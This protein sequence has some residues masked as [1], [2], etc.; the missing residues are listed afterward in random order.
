MNLVFAC[1]FVCLFVL[2]TIFACHLLLHSKVYHRGLSSYQKGILFDMLLKFYKSI[3][4]NNGFY[5]HLTRYQSQPHIA[6]SLL[7][8]LHDFKLKVTSTQFARCSIESVRKPNST[9]CTGMWTRDSQACKHNSHNT[10]NLRSNS[11]EF[12]QY[13][14]M[15]MQKVGTRM[16]WSFVLVM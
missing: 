9:A 12:V 11:T 6:F 4:Q 16:G 7:W 14:G 13:G 2:S 5:K 10:A 3:E 8:S 15:H 1:L